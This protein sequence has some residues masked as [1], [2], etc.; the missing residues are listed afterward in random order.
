MHAYEV[1]AHE[2]HANE[3][4]VSETYAYRA[5]AYEIYTREMLVHDMYAYETYDRKVHTHDKERD[6][7]LLACEKHE[8]VQPLVLLSLRLEHFN[9]DAKSES[10]LTPKS[11]EPPPDGIQAVKSRHHIYTTNLQNTPPLL[12]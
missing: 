4:Y 1:H 5:H 12:V 2:M 7:H 11:D 3:M 9:P 10:L 6:T 8:T